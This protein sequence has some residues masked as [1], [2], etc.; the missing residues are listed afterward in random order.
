VYRSVLALGALASALAGPFAAARSRFIDAK[1]V[2]ASDA[3]RSGQTILLGLEMIPQRGW[4]GYWSNPGES[5]LAPVVKWTA[6]RG[7]HFGQLEHPAPTLMTVMGMTSYVHAGPYIL[8][9]H[10]KLDANLPTGTILPI[11]GDVTWAACSDK[12]CVPERARLALRLKVGN[13][14]PSPQAGLL[15][16]A[17]AREPRSI[18]SGS[19]SVRGERIILRLPASAQLRPNGTRFFPDDNGYWD[20]LK[21]RVVAGRPLTLVS[22]ARSKVPKVITGVVS[23]GSSAY[24]LSFEVRTGR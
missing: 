22:P 11:A 9:T 2:A 18:G 4:H 8:L 16:A 21:A 3:S 1:L 17:L 19:A 13:G 5:G 7:V 15:R 10:V 14:L 12:L 6:P 20:P 23:D 24:R